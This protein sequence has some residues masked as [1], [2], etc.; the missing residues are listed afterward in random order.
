M[1]TKDLNLNRHSTRFIFKFILDKCKSENS[2]VIKI[3][4]TRIARETMYSCKT[5]AKGLKYLQEQGYITYKR[6]LLETE[7]YAT[8]TTEIALTEKSIAILN[9]EASKPQ[10]KPQNKT[11]KAEP[12]QPQAEAEKTPQTAAPTKQR[13]LSEEH[14]LKLSKAMKAYWQR[15]QNKVD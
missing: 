1:I 4:Q 14:R 13:K 12:R 10:N 9:A 5:V 3:E 15:Y 7:F 6:A 2:N 8:T 11:I